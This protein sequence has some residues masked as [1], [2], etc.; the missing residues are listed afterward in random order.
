MWRF[1]DLF[2]SWLLLS[3]KGKYLEMGC[4]TSVRPKPNRTQSTAYTEPQIEPETINLF[5][6]SIFPVSERACG[7]SFSA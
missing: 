1:Y 4:T 2:H 7:Y 6:T 5:P 3:I